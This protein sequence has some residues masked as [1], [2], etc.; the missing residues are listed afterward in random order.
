MN[1]ART[2]MVVCLVAGVAAG[3]GFGRAGRAE[4]TDAALAPL[5]AETQRLGEQ[6]DLLT[7]GQQAL[8]SQV[9]AARRDGQAAPPSPFA[10]PTA[11]P[12]AAATTEKD[13]PVDEDVVRE[14]VAKGH[15]LIA[16]AVATGGWSEAQRDALREQLTVLP[17]ESVQAL[18]QEL[19][20]A[21][22]AGKIHPDFRGGPF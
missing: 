15:E 9:I 10:P 2:G 13:P 8:A 16:S 4:R 1:R 6:L 11:A 14:H 3:V 19:G 22:N 7:R 17:P 18:V 12:A 20:M 5:V 21:I